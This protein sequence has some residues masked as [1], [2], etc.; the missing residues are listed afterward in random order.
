VRGNFSPGASERS[1]GLTKERKV[2]HWSTSVRQLLERE[3][4]IRKTRR[5]TV[6]GEER[7][8]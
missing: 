7:V 1:S 5:L 3:L 6:D 4:R 8:T 2:N